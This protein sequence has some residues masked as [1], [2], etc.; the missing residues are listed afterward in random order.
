MLKPWTKPTEHKARLSNNC[1]YTVIQFFL[2][3]TSVQLEA[4]VHCTTVHHTAIQ[5]TI[6]LELPDNN[7]QL[8]SW[9]EASLRK[10]AYYIS[11]KPGEGGFRKGVQHLDQDS[12]T[13]LEVPRTGQ[14]KLGFC[15]PYKTLCNKD[16]KWMCNDFPTSG[17]LCT[18][19]YHRSGIVF[20]KGRYA[21]MFQNCIGCFFKWV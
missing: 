18:C 3:R 8:R 17:T 5:P 21:C 11:L 6:C 20:Y 13:H 9:L 4:I 12:L 19:T 7:Q 10:K 15:D 1:M 16:D 14:Q 2:M